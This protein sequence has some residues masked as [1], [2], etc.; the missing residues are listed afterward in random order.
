MSIESTSQAASSHLCLGAVLGKLFLTSDLDN[1]RWGLVLG[2]LLLGKRN[3]VTCSAAALVLG[4]LTARSCREHLERQ[5]GKVRKM[6]R[7]VGN[8]P[9]KNCGV[10]LDLVFAGKLLVDSGVDSTE[11]RGALELTGGISPFRCE[12]LAVAAPRSCL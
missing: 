4:E 12:I 10:A 3:N 8:D 6:V 11:L 5:R 9:Y 1:L 2:S 7:I